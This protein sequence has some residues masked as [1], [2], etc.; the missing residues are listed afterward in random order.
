MDKLGL[1]HIYCGDGKGKTTAALGLTLRAAG[2]GLY[3]VFA[4][5]LKSWNTGELTSLKKLENVTVLRSEKPFPFTDKMTEQQMTEIKEIHNEIFMKASEMASNGKCDLL[6]L[7]EIIST[8]NY[9]FIDKAIV[10]GFLEKRPSGVELVLTGRNPSDEFVEM[11][12]YVSEV[13][14]VKHPFDAGVMA[15]KGIES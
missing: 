13:R 6:V 7:D 3:V 5:F 1:L 11:A 14:K 2:S 15:R 4:Q 10:D 8:Y 12:D 9:E